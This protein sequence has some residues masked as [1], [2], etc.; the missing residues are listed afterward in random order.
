MKKRAVILTAIVALICMSV[1]SAC[2]S[3][4]LSVGGNVK[5]VFD[6]GGGVYRNSNLPVTHYY[7]F[8]NG[9]ENLICDLTTV[10]KSEFT[11]AGRTLYGW[12]LTRIE[13]GEGKYEYSDEWDF[14]SDRVTVAEDGT[15]SYPHMPDGAENGCITLYARW[16]KVSVWRYE[17]HG[18]DADGKPVTESDGNGGEKESVF[19]SYDVREDG[20]RKFND[21]QPKDYTSYRFRY[22]GHTPEVTYADGKYAINYYNADG[23]PFDLDYEHPCEQGADLTVNVYVKFIEGMF[24]Y[25]STKDELERYAAE[26]EN[27]YLM[28]DIDFGGEEFAGFAAGNRFA[29][30]TIFGNDHTISNF[31][32]ATDAS[33]SNLVNDSALGTNL[34]YISMFGN[35]SDSVI[36]D[37]AFTDVAIEIDVSYSEIKG[38]YCSPLFVTCKN[39]TIDNVSVSGSIRCVRAEIAGTDDDIHVV[40]DKPSF[41]DPVEGSINGCTVNMAYSDE[42][43]S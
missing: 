9:T 36:K 3:S 23:T 40:T 18:L 14:A 11:Y 37:L 5:V 27:L 29:G 28:D 42:R 13:V 35:G 19:Y 32:L 15:V 10:G 24:T 43:N 1:L 25:V 2:S 22:P 34:L 31:A 20:N 16:E 12:Y 8:E 39:C 4:V 17:V 26:N 6:L 21:S 38:V 30:R 33:R 41:V 7:N